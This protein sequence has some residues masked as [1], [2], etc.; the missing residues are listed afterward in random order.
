MEITRIIEFDL[1]KDIHQHNF[2][3]FSLG[4][5][6]LVILL[7]ICLQPLPCLSLPPAQDV[8][9]E[10]LRTEV[11]FGGRSPVD[12]K[13]LSA[14]EYE[15]LEAELTESRLKPEIKGDIQELIF[16]LQIRKLIKTIIPFY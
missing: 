11:I 2:Q 6:T 10:I 1:L 14:S 9:E 13:S 5:P 16:L 8:P 12:G 15:E 7:L 4:K 3:V